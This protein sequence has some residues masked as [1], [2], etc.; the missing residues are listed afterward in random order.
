[1]KRTPLSIGTGLGFEYVVMGRCEKNER[2]VG[3]IDPAAFTVGVVRHE[4]AV[5]VP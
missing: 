2:V 5:E 3:V 4:E 1:M